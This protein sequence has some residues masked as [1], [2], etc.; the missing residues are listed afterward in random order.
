MVP[1]KV[2]FF[3]EIILCP[4]SN[5]AIINVTLLLFRF[6]LWLWLWL[7]LWLQWQLQVKWRSLYDSCICNH[8]HDDRLCCLP[9][10]HSTI[11]WNPSIAATLGEQ[12]FGCYIEV[13]FIAVFFLGPGCLA[14]TEVA[15]IQGWPLWKRGSTVYSEYEYTNQFL[16]SY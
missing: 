14:A 15:F 8:H 1:W 6:I 10:H 5:E 9:C 16:K 2:I 13:A 7:W 12:H 3:S 11:Q 4:V